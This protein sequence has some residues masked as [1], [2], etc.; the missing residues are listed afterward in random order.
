MASPSWG[1][2]VSV[3]LSLNKI[4]RV[5]CRLGV[6]ALLVP[7]LSGC[8]R[9]RNVRY[10]QGTWYNNDAHLLSVVGESPLE[11][12]WTFWS[13]SFS[14]EA[15]CF[16]EASISG[17]YRILESE[18]DTLVLELFNMQG[19]Q[20]GYAVRQGATGAVTIK[21]DREADILRINGSGP[22]TRLTPKSGS[23][24]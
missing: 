15:C 10:V 20:Q 3:R 11:Q 16:A 4:L 22:F 24:E 8:L 2:E 9:D 5:A 23:E 18:G 7:L 14:Q 17:S 13:G 21:I 12:W 1:A 6:A 19:H